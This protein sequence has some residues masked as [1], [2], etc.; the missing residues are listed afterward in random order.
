M[1]KFISF[2]IGG[3]LTTSVFAGIIDAPIVIQA[4]APNGALI[5]LHDV[6]GPCVNGAKLA[7]WVS[8]NQK[9]RIQGCWKASEDVLSISWF[10]AEPS[11]IP[12][13]AFL[14]NQLKPNS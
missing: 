1:N 11:Q 9:E 7:T 3:L 10:D 13:R 6:E 14:A 4:R 12:M 5:Q 8:P 2:L